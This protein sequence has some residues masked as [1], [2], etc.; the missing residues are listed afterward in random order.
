ME[1]L[2]VGPTELFFIVLIAII[3]LGPKDMAKTGGAIGAWLNKFIHS[4]TWKTLRKTSDDL[5]NLPTQLMREDNLKKY[6]EGEETTDPKT[7]QPKRDAW[8]GR[9]PVS[10]DPAAG[11]ADENVI[12]AQTPTE[13]PVVTATPEPSKK[14]PA[15]PRK[16]TST[17]KK[18]TTVPATTRIPRKKSDE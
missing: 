12:Y 4:D 5:R 16:K 7:E 14:K 2:G 17:V 15:A 13:A 1:F 18:K 8:T 6:L 10:A 3:F 9:A 11:R